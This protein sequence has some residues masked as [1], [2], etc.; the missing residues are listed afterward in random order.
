MSLYDLIRHFAPSV[1]ALEDDLKE[2]PNGDLSQ[3]GEHGTALSGGQKARVSLA[4]WVEL[5]FISNS[6]LRMTGK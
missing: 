5:L 1:C 4:R 2:L 6:D 3:V